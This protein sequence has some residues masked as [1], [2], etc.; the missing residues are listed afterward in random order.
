MKPD[1]HT[2]L[3]IV[4]Q[5][6]NPE[7]LDSFCKVHPNN[8]MFCK[9]YRLEIIKYLLDIN[10]VDY[11]NP[12]NLIY[13][14]HDN[15]YN[16]S[17]ESVFDEKTGTFDLVGVYKLYYNLNKDAKVIKMPS[18][19]ITSVPVLHNLVECDFSHNML[20]EFPVQP[21]L[22]K[23]NLSHNL[24]TSFPS[25][26]ML[27]ECYL[28]NNELASFTVQP[29]MKICDLSNNKLLTF[30]IQ[31]NM[32]VCQLDNNL[33]IN[34]PIQ[35]NLRILSIINNAL[36]YRTFSM[37]PMMIKCVGDGNITDLPYCMNLP[38]NNLVPLQL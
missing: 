26:P 4:K 23:C 35:P 10:K 8:R 19:F 21:A 15:E 30:P 27:K 14:Y 16:D 29:E 38:T 28:L 17:F 20:L 6:K 34:F 1:Y 7:D 2:V 32:V 3:N 13:V 37:Q 18:E 12:G 9:Y 36:T 31:P 33:L 22:E 25:Q 11:T 24:L 5:I